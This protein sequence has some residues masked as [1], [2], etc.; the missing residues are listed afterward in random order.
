MEERSQMLELEGQQTLTQLNTNLSF[1]VSRRQNWKKKKKMA[2]YYK[3]AVYFP[4][5]LA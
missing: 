3:H 2:V 5:T 1:L 4:K